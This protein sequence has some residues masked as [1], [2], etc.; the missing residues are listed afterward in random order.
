MYNT[1]H[2]TALHYTALVILSTVH[3]NAVRLRTLQ[4]SR[5][6]AS[7]W[8]TEPCVLKVVLATPSWGYDSSGGQGVA[9]IIQNE[10]PGKKVRSSLTETH[11]LPT[12][13]GT[14]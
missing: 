11:S 5:N 13:R 2:R 1:L 8:S 10:I 3:C 7:V 12:N 9:E 4:F 6:C 14:V